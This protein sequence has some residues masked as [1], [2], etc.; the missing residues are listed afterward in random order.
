MLYTPCDI[1]VVMEQRD[2]AEAPLSEVQ[3]ANGVVLLGRK[4][5]G[6]F[7]IQRVI[8][9]NSNVYLLYEYQPGTVVKLN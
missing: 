2:G 3:L 4:V 1:T 6:G 7:E 5:E 9:S 8:S